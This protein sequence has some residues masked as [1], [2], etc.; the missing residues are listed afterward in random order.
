MSHKLIAQVSRGANTGLL[1]TPHLHKDGMYVV[2][3]PLYMDTRSNI[4]WTAHHSTW[5]P[6][7]FGYRPNAVL[8]KSQEHGCRE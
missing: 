4:S 8:E 2:Q 5:T 1:L 3:I 7:Y 6:H